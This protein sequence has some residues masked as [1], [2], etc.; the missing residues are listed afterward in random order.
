M[1]FKQEENPIFTYKLK[2]YDL[3]CGKEELVKSYSAE[4][5]VSVVFSN[6]GICNKVHPNVCVE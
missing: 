3:C 5:F 6:D 2:R 4:A 1:G